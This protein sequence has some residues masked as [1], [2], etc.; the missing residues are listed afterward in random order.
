[1]AEMTTYQGRDTLS[2]LLAFPRLYET[3]SS[4]PVEHAV[5]IHA[6]VEVQIFVYPTGST[7]FIARWVRRY[8]SCHAF[9]VA[10]HK[11]IF[12]DEPGIASLLNA[13]RV[14]VVAVV[15]ETVDNVGYRAPVVFEVNVVWVHRGAVL[16]R[17]GCYKGRK[18]RQKAKLEDE[19]TLVN[20]RE[21]PH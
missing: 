17:S 9:A 4:L 13:G 6:V 21:Y 8:T 14:R 12:A 20:C 19:A 18:T 16:H 3:L 7:D 1:M 2:L 11:P 5:R 10:S 15:F